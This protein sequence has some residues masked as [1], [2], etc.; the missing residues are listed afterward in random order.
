MKRVCSKTSNGHLRGLIAA[1]SVSGSPPLHTSGNSN[2]QNTIPSVEGASNPTPQASPARDE[3]AD[4]AGEKATGWVPESAKPV[5]NTT[6]G[7]GL[8][9]PRSHDM[10][11]KMDD[12]QYNSDSD[13]DDVVDVGL[14]NRFMLDNFAGHV[15]SQ[16]IYTL[17]KKNLE[18]KYMDKKGVDHG[19]TLV[20][21][22]INYL[23]VLED[24]VDDL[25]TSIEPEAYQQ[26]KRQGLV[27]H[28][29]DCAVELAVKFF[30]S[31][32]YLDEDGS[33]PKIVDEP[34]K[35]TFMSSHDDQSLIRV[36]YSTSRDNAPSPQMNADAN[37]P[38]AEDIDIVSFGISSESISSFFA[39]RLDI[40]T[41]D[42]HLIRF[43][44]PFRPLIRNI[45]RVREQLQKLE[46]NYG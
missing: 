44:K 5:A 38:K 19:S 26:K 12:F 37:P 6:K 11:Q 13:S 16:S 8:A 3:T 34:D 21:S 1:N 32:A 18:Q 33:F 2:N 43:G 30:R 36:L 20:T 39:S 40:G 9:K 42:S 15:N 4:A 46:G 28:H 41:K 45:G 25:E 7:G 14:S 23:R 10:E 31:A 22:L 17:Y 29:S 27:T 35:G 24:R